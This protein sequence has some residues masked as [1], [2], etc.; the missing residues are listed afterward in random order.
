MEEQ[1]VTATVSLREAADQVGVSLRTM[2]RYVR[3]G[4]VKATLT[5][6][7][8]GPEYRIEPDHVEELRQRRDDVPGQGGEGSRGRVVVPVPSTVDAT[9]AA[10][11][12][13]DLVALQAAW[14]RIADLE[15]E[16]ATLKAQVAQ[17]SAGGRPG[18]LR[19]LFG[20]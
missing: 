12:A 19:R 16:N 15:A 14:Q 20:G 18:L 6:G 11:V 9:L 4:T 8:H 1:T 10:R 7:R 3:E 2:R 5:T 13:D 17:V